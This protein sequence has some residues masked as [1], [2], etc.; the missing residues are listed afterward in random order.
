MNSLGREIFLFQLLLALAL[1]LLII[2]FAK[3]RVPM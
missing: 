2:V 3:K 1:G